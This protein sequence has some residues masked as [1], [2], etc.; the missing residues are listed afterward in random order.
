MYD[1]ATDPAYKSQLAWRL[2]VAMNDAVEIEAT[3][4]KL[5]QRR[6]AR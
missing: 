1:D 2:G 5:D 6:G 4:Q 3:R